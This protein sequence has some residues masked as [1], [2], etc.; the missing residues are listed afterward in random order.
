MANLTTN[1]KDALA[2]IGIT[3]KDKNLHWKTNYA[4]MKYRTVSN[5]HNRWYDLTTE[6]ENLIEN[7]RKMKAHRYLI[8]MGYTFDTNRRNKVSCIWY[9]HSDKR[10]H[11]FISGG[12]VYEPV[13]NTTEAV[14]LTQNFRSSQKDTKTESTRFPV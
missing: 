9:S 3:G 11:A 4:S 8:D 5:K 12:S 2:Y 7:N 6:G 10:G 14:K 13:S 1:Q